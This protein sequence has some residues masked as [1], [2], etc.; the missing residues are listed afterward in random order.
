MSA[1]FWQELI[2]SGVMEQFT[3]ADPPKDANPEV[4]RSEPLGFCLYFCQLHA[5]A[6]TYIFSFIHPLSKKS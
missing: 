4:G 2:P 1:H 5:D 6:K 3:F